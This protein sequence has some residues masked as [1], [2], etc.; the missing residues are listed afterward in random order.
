MI[1][2]KTSGEVIFNPIWLKWFIDLAKNLTA[3]GAGSGGLTSITAGAGLDGGVITT[4]GTI[5]VGTQDKLDFD[6]TP[7]AENAVGRLRWNSTDGTLNLGMDFAGVV[8]QIGQEV[9]LPPLYNNTGGTIDDGTII[10][11]TGYDAGGGGLTFVKFIAD[12]TMNHISAVSMV[13]S[14]MAN[15]TRGLATRSGYIRD[16]DT[17]GAPYGETW[18][19]GE[20]L[21]AS[22]TV[23]GGMTN[24]KPVA[25]ASA[26]PLG[27][28]VIVH[29]TTGVFLILT[30]NLTEPV[31]YGVFSSSVS[32]PIAAVDTIQAI[33]YNATDASSGITLGTPTSRVVIEHSGI[34]NFQ[35]SVQLESGTASSRV[36]TIWPRINGVDVP[37]TGTHITIKSNTD[38]LVPAWNFVFAITANDYFELMWAADGNNVTLAASAAQT[39]PFA[40]PAVPSIILT[41][42]QINQ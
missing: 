25:P 8:N 27:I 1:P 24:V 15:G 9:Y 12:G 31:Y 29:A 21:Y 10:G 36:I 4:T 18:V 32:Q 35:F 23:A 22:D 19:A 26:F 11:V 30:P 14:D 39:V 3:A 34:Y 41:V 42:T 20:T 40:H 38:V 13:T 2:G 16:L 5:S 6:L 7:T 28:V 33:T 37:N 17:T